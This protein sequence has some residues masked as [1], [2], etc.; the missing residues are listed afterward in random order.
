MPLVFASIC[1]HPPIII[2]EIGRENTKEVQKTIQALK[3][4]E[5]EIGKKAPEAILIISPHG[6]V[7]PDKMSVRSQSEYFG[8]FALFGAPEVDFHFRGDSA[9]SQ[10]IVSESNQA[11]IPALLL[12]LATCQYYGLETTLDHGTLVPIYF[13]LR[14]LTEVPIV[15]I[16]FSYLSLEDHFKF[17]QVLAQISTNQ[18]IALI[19]SGDLSHALTYDAPAGYSPL[20]QEFDQTLIRLIKDN[21]VE[22]IRKMDVGLVEEAAE[23]GFRSILILLGALSGLK[24][25]PQI[26]SY[27]G[28]FGVGYLVANFKIK[29]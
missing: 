3:K 7:F 20:G 29:S 1:P 11:G 8:N 9:L 21:K 23:C 26:L 28:P 5:E 22:E 25:K 15:P 16:A 10:K 24:I 14:N 13:L 18:R 12:D 17:G 19:A 4:L 6:P 2:P 27:E